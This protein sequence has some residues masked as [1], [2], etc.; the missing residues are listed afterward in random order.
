[1][2]I[3][4]SGHRSRISKTSGARLAR[5]AIIPGMPIV[6]G[7]EV[8]KTTSGRGSTRP[9]AAAARVNA[10]NDARRMPYEKVCA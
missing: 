6:S 10:A 4:A 3:G 2:A 5:A 9:A 8:A 7:V 1:M